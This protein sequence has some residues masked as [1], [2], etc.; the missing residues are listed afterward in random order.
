LRRSWSSLRYS[1]APAT[2]VVSNISPPLIGNRR[3][4]AAVQRALVSASPPHA[5]LFVGPDG[6]GKAALAR[7]LAQALNCEQNAIASGGVGAR[8]AERHSTSNDPPSDNDSSGPGASLD[9]SPL[10]A[11]PREPCGECAQCLRIARGIHSDV[12]NVSIPA[13]EPNEPLHKDI[14]VD[15]VR[16]VERAVS[17]APFEGRTHVVIIDPADAMSIGAQNAF[18]KTLEEPPPNAAFVLIA[19]R[20]DRLLETVRSRCRR[21]EFALVPVGDIEAALI[22]RGVEEAQARLLA[23]LAGGRPERALELA[24]NP[25]RVDKRREVLA[26]ARQMGSL[27]MSDL[28]DLSER[29]AARFREDRE[30]VLSRI[31]AWIGWWRDLVLV[32][33]GAEEAAVN[34]DLLDGLREDSGRYAPK[35]VVAFVQ[36][37]AECRKRLEYNV[38][39][40]IALDAMLVTAPRAGQK[41]HT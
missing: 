11:P 36:A 20:E 1:S 28:M 34:V 40:R 24:E 17:L 21:V 41:S 2:L 33:S 14:S 29:L 4:L 13:P 25:S 10:R 39:A 35:D 15:Q 26:Q 3:A 8:H 6:V 5:W 9:A 31:N 38:Q 23:R 12:T 7:W 27:P 18:L 30:A 32:Q 22:E 19:T 37:L 16:E